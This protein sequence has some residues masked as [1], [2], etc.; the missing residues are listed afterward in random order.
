MSSREERMQKALT[1]LRGGDASAA[2][3][4]LEQLVAEGPVPAATWLALAFARVNLDQA[5]AALAAVDQALTLEPRNVRALLFKAD[6]LDRMGQPRVALGFYQAALRVAAGM[7]QVP[8]DVARGMERAQEVCD[9]WAADYEDYLLDAMET[10]GFTRREQPRFAESLDIACGKVLVQLQQPTRYYFPGLPQRAFYERGEFTWAAGLEAHTDAIRAELLGL[11]GG[12]ELFE[13]Y[14]ESDPTRPRLNDS[15]NFDSMDWSA[16]Y[17]WREGTLVEEVASRCP[18]TMAALA[19]VPL[20]I[21]PGQMP[22]VLFSSLAPGARIEPHH[23]AVNSRLICHL[24]LLVPQN[25]GELRVGNDSRPWREGE[26]LV[27][28]DSVEHEAWN[29]SNETRV[30]LLFDIWRPELTADERHWVSTMLQAV[31]AFQSS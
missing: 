29:Q 27:F 6:H 23:G 5:E 7:S 21:I 10:A 2:V 24:P 20:C 22:S 30:V 17:L 26:L 1:A 25:C 13:P 14:L 19:A 11:M 31:K 4:M 12:A 28:D 18:R 8:V 16:C 9:R 3:S 15:R